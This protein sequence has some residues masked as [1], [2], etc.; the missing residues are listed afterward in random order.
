MRKPRGHNLG[1]SRRVVH[2]Q[3]RT[4]EPV[5]SV[6]VMHLYGW[7]SGRP[8]ISEVCVGASRPGFSVELLGFV[9]SAGYT[10]QR[11]MGVT[12]WWAFLFERVYFP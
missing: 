5:H 2:L 4:S 11:A 10:L 1:S 12:C 7:C 3:A 6:A 9:G 8:G